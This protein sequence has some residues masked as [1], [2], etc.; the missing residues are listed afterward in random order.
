MADERTE[1][2][3]KHLAD[4]QAVEKHILEAVQ[5]QREE[6]LVR[7][8][9]DTNKLLIEV[10]RTL[11]EHVQA[12]A[13]L[14]EEYDGEGESALKKAITAAAGVVAGLYDKVREHELTRMLRDDYTALS[15]ASMGYTTLHTFGL[16]VKEQRIA[17][18]A[19]SH[20]KEI[21]PLMV[22]ISKVLPVV[23]AREVAK[24]ND[25]AVDTSVGEEAVRNTQTAWDASVT[26]R[27]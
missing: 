19:L 26:E 7:N 5:R 12:L 13:N 15:L 3:Q 16:A 24:E 17:D 14:S 6:D 27:V 2:I 1:A 25:F 18:V 20:L 10:E 8:D 11:K 22:E 9:L 4:M 23:T 21:T